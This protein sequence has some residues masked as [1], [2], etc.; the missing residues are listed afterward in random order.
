MYILRWRNPA[1]D[2]NKGTE[3]QVPV[4]SV[5]SDKAS[6]RF[7]GK[8]AANYGQIQQENLMR[9]LENFADGTAPEHPTVG[10]EWYDTTNAILRVCSSTSP[11]KWKSL[12]G[13][14][15]T[16]AGTDTAP[17]PAAVGDVWFE[18]TGPASGVLYVYTG[19]GRYP[20]TTTTIGG[21]NQIWPQV[22]VTAGREEY[23][24]ALSVVN[25]LVDITAGGSGALGKVI[26]NL[27]T[28]TS[29]DT[30]L[31]TK[32]SSQLDTNVLTPTSD[33]SE[34]LVDVN[35]GDWDTLLAA[36][37]YAINRLDLPVGFVDDVS[38]VPFVSDGRQAP[39]SL[40]ALAT[41]DVRYP[42]LE[43]RSNRRFGSATL[44]QLYTETMNVLAVA[45]QNRYTLKGINGASGSNAS[46]ASNVTTAHHV[47]FSGSPAGAT[48]VDFGLRF[49]F[50]NATALSSFINSG[51][52]IQVTLTHAPGGSGTTGDTNLK[53]L[54]DSRGVVRITA[55]KTRVFSNTLP[56]TLSAVPG[57]LGFKD[58]AVSGTLTTQTVAGATATLT[59]QNG[60]TYLLVRFV[61][62]STGPMNGTLT[63][64][65]DVIKDTETYLAP[66]VTAVY[67]A[68]LAY[69]SG[70]KYV[71]AFLT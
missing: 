54:L 4:A 64:R 25:Q 49:N 6:I 14:Q 71:G 53:T 5:V 35:S 10:Q 62:S 16:T 11:L 55:D 38:P 23:N 2:V 68:P 45:Q 41:T 26:T 43:R 66:A 46:F 20:E 21:W 65:Y 51:G 9:L 27:S 32:F 18:R 47:T 34:L 50:A 63:A 15:V 24:A 22:E 40:T 56:L 28:L 33:S 69:A 7:T 58:V 31:Q 19:L 48:S 52:A 12:A 57:T 44:N 70:D 60:G 29:K 61:L 17:S 13:V 67:S 1:L 39:T 30:D 42:S 36:A 59:S 37:K 8:G 3:I